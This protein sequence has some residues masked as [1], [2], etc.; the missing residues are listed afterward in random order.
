MKIL[1][2]SF[3]LKPANT[4]APWAAF[5][6]ALLLAVATSPAHSETADKLYIFT[7]NYGQFNYSLQG[8]GFEHKPEFIGGTST[9]FVKK[10]LTEAG[11]PYR[12]KLRKWAVSYD[13]ALTRPYYGVYSTARTAAREE[14]FHWVGPIAQ[15]NWVLFVKKG[16][17]IRINSIE[18]LKKYKVGGYKGSATTAFLVEQ[19]IEVSTLPND[20]VNPRRLNDGFIDVWIASDASA[21]QLAEDAGYPNIERAMVIR[22]VDMYLAMNKSTPR[23]WLDKLE[24]AYEKL[25]AAG[26]LKLPR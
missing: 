2:T 1:P 22:T 12:M 17:N 15:Y 14:L 8:R 26:E 23:E 4:L 6:I 20:S 11:L 5:L 3:A 16:S 21:Y 18:D 7:E 19:G 10:L 24:T 25:V 9:D 13:R